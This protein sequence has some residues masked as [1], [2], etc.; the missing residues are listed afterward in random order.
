MLII[1]IDDISG[2]YKAQDGATELM[3]LQYKKLVGPNG[4]VSN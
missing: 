2:M 3:A 1:S 4:A